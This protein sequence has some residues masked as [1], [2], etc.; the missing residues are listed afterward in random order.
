VI[1][2]RSS[3]TTSADRLQHLRRERP[4]VP[5]QAQ[6]TLSLRLSFGRRSGRRCSGRENSRQ[7][8]RS[9]R[10]ASRSGIRARCPEAGHLV[11]AEVSGRL[12]PIF[13]PVQPLSLCEAV[14]IAT[15][16]H[17]DRTGRNRPWA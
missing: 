6:T 7:R 8:H 13:T 1:E 16:A 11:G 14:T 17:R 2:P 10:P 5:P 4:A 12:A 15:Q 3:R 9:R